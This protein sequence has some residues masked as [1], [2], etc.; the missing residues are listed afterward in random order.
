MTKF[1]KMLGKPINALALFVTISMVVLAGS[2]VVFRYVL[3]VSV[4]WTE[5]VARVF[6]IWLIFIG[7]AKVEEEG[8]Q[9]RT[10]LFIDKLPRALRFA[11]EVV[12]SLCSILFQIILFIGSVQSFS[13]ERHLSLGSVPWIDY[14]FLFAPVIIA[15]PL[16]IYFMIANLFGAHARLYPKKEA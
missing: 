10:L 7:T 13:S 9:V 5:E 12:I 4:P 6:F 3:K 2:Q 14:R 15:S 1:S 16:C 11:W 8:S